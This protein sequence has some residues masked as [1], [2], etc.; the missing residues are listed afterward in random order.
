MATASTKQDNSDDEFE[1]ADEG[2]PI[3]PPVI[4][5]AISSPPP[6][7]IQPPIS[8][9]PILSPPS[10]PIPP[11]NKN[12]QVQST[13]PP[14]AVTDGWG[15]WNIDDEQPIE[16][17]VKTT[18]L[19]QQD[20]RSS[21]SSS[22]SRTGG[23]LSQIGS[24]ED[25]ESELSNQ[26]RLQRKKYRKKQLE[27]NLNKDDNK[28]NARIPRPAERCDEETSSLTTTTTT[29]TKHDVKDAHHVLDCLAEQSP[30]RTVE[31]TK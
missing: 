5:P 6:E 8:N 29:T 20:S 31:L 14:P 30:S 18:N 21:H 7:P 2:E 16:N 24:D 13:A 10:E 28:I 27:S 9:P 11:S 23:S 15:D 26:Q 22:P 19:L 12:I 3:S 4:K 25:D 1:S 17:P